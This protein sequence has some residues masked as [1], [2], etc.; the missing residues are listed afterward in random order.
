MLLNEIIKLGE[1]F[2]FDHPK[3]KGKVVLYHIL[4]IFYLELFLHLQHLI[5]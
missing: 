1:E 4:L 3:V 2:E 5:F